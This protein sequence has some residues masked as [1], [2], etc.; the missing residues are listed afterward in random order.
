MRL[1][2]KTS[3][4]FLNGGS[5][6][7]TPLATPS[8]MSPPAM[9]PGKI[10]LKLKSSQPPTPATG[11]PPHIPIAPAPPTASGRVPK[12][13]PKKRAK[14]DVDSDDEVPLSSGGPNKR[15]KLNVL[16]PRPQASRTS[17]IVVKP[18]FQASRAPPPRPRGEGY[19]SEDDTR[20]VDPFIEEQFILRM[21][22]GEHCDYLNQKVQE[23]KIGVPLKDGGA[24]FQLK[25][26]PGVERR[27]FLS[28]KGTHFAS[29]LVDLPTITESMKTWDRKNFMKSADIC[30]MLLVFQQVA[31]EAEAKT[32]ALP[33][34]VAS[35]YR[36]PHGLTPPMHDCIHRRFR[37]RLSKKEIKDKEAE[38]QRL[39]K[40]DAEAVVTSWE[41]IDD[42]REGMKHDDEAEGGSIGIE[43][44]ADGLFDDD[45]DAVGEMDDSGGYFGYQNGTI[46]EEPI[47]EDDLMAEFME[48]DEGEAGGPA[49]GTPSQ[50][51]A[52]PAT[53]G[54]A[55]PAAQ[56]VTV[57]E[58]EEDEESDE[59]E[60]DE[61]TAAKAKQNKADREDIAELETRLEQYL[62]NR[63][64]T[65]NQLLQKRIDEGIRKTRA[66][67]R[68]I[69]ARM[70]ITDEDD[71][72]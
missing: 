72:A 1:K 63:A 55:T 37:K 5:I 47:N 35:D 64:S 45:T 18:S 54:A 22:P 31:N 36:W 11:V 68:L 41:L 2:L 39:L 62:K 14:A 60:M 4:S 26:L 52:T 19:D 61:E 25:W 20:E 49:E 46:Q 53:T 24:D 6:T 27:A 40:A 67:I 51:A 21:P 13:T 8:A 33:P 23:R 44:D 59:D 29:V 71:D 65:V 57:E 66:E 58:S 69:K 7:A 42:A 38:L 10:K 15:V 50:V 48:D 34:M 17:S 9:T 43:E 12:P 70:G 30:Q 16:K 32:A 28:V 3:S 56:D